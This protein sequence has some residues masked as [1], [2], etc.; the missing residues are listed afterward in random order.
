MSY[1]GKGRE[2]LE[3]KRYFRKG[4]RKGDDSKCRLRFER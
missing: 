4:S 1:S 3:G 2:M